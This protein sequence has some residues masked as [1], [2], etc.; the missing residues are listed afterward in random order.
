MV[1]GSARSLNSS[2]LD[3][4]VQHHH[5][6]G[7]QRRVRHLEEVV[8]TVAPEVLEGADRHDAID[9]FGELLPAVEQNAFAS[10]GVRLGEQLGHVRLLVLAKGKTD[11]VDVVALDG[12]LDGGT[13]ATTDVQQRHPRLKAQ[14]AQRQI[15]LR[16]LGFF[17]RHVIALEVRTAVGLRGIQEEPEEV[18]GQVVMR[19]H[20]VEVRLQVLVVTLC[21]RQDSAFG[22]WLRIVRSS[23]V[24]RAAP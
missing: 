13:P 9:V 21:V 15:D 5:A 16:D 7:R 18:V 23:A 24:W 12:P 20:V 3:D 1:S 19:L 10:W 6:A 17:K 8:V 4:R 14:L 11:D 2:S 22:V